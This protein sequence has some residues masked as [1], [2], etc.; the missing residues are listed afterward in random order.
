M[1]ICLVAAIIL[2]LCSSVASAGFFDQVSRSNYYGIA[3]EDGHA[4]FNQ[5]MLLEKELGI[6]VYATFDMMTTYSIKNQPLKRYQISLD[7]YPKLILLDGVCLSTGFVFR[8]EFSP[9]WFFDIH[10]T[11]R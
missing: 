5:G 1:R 3:L 6:G 9:R 8:N 11:G 4:L 7:W 2:C 10:I